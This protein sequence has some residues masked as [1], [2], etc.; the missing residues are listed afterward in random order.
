MVE[1]AKSLTADPKIT[2]R[3]AGAEDLSFLGDATVDLAVAGQAAHWFDYERAW[4]ELSRAVRPGG[5]LAFWGYKDNIILGYPQL[6]PVYHR[7]VYGTGE[8]RPGLEGLGR[9][10][11][12][13]GRTVL[14]ESFS[15]IIPPETEWEDVTR[16][17]WEP[18][19]SPTGGIEKAPKEALWLRKQLKLGDCEDY[20]R[21][22]SSY[23]NWKVDYPEKKSRAEGGEGDIVDAIL[24]AFVEAVPEWK[25]MGDKWRD[26]EVECVWGTCLLMA[27]RRNE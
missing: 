9:F 16:V 11:E 5:S 4:P 23:N 3:Q 24:E 19:D 20:L 6:F 26:V 17:N 27:K 13:P 1:Q 21:T 14:K 10:W 8:V 2:F 12:N 25:A 22:Y 7:F 18:D 15:A